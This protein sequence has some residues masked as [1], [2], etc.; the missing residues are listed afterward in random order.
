MEFTIFEMEAEK[1]NPKSYKWEINK[2]NNL[3]GFEIATNKHKFTWQPH[4]S[5][6]TI[7]YDV[8][9]DAVKFKIKRPPVLDF[10]ET[11]KQLGFDKSWVTIQDNKNY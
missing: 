5:Q 2:R 11:I 6:F 8:P 3:E 7:I 9:D 10:N 4:G 1:Y